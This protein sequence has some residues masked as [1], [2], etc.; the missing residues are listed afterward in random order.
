MTRRPVR[1]LANAAAVASLVLCLAL[2][3]G[4]CRAQLGDRVWVRFAGHSLIFYGADGAYVGAAR[5]YF[6]NPEPAVGDGAFEGPSGL[7]RL[8]R[9]GRL[10]TTAAS[11][12]GVELYRDASGPVP[13]FR[14]VVIPLAYPIALAALLPAAWTVRTLRAR[15][16]TKSGHCPACGYDCRATPDRCPECGGVPK[17]TA[18]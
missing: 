12:A 8:L 18:Q 11:V 17:A 13:Q 15:R 7:L 16:R 10:G 9:A 3:V 1:T 2:I 6:F 5:T 4:W 14:A